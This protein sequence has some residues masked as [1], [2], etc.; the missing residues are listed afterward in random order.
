[1]ALDAIDEFL[2]NM[3]ADRDVSPRARDGR[4]T[5]LIRIRST[6]P[7]GYWSVRLRSDGYDFV[8][9]DEEPDAELS[10]PSDEVLMVVLRRRDLAIPTS[11]CQETVRWRSTGWPRL[12]FSRSARRPSGNENL[13]E[14]SSGNGQSHQSDG[15][16]VA[17]PHEH[18]PLELPEV[19]AAQ[20]R[21]RLIERRH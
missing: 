7:A 10:G 3:K 19:K 11:R 12:L 20:Q 6:S 17:H 18:D 21:G 15:Q 13:L 2:A 4:D 8:D 5:E 16:E 9:T 14:A 1:M